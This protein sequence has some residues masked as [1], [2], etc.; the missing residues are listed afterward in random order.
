[1]NVA[2]IIKFYFTLIQGKR[3]LCECHARFFDN[4]VHYGLNVKI[5]LFKIKIVYLEFELKDVI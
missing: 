5:K 1:M 2:L 3:K 4:V